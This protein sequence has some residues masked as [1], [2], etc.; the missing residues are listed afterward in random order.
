MWHFLIIHIF[1]YS[2]IVPPYDSSV[3]ILEH[4][5][6]LQQRADPVYS[7]PLQVYGLTWR[8]KV[9]PVCCFCIMLVLY[10]FKLEIL[11]YKVGSTIAQTSFASDNNQS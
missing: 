10:I 11:C 2:E 6:V 4:F 8:L 9:Y 3:C 5:T 7:P 1:C